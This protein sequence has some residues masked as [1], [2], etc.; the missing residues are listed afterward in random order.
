MHTRSMLDRAMVATEVAVV[1]T[2]QSR[3][4]TPWCGATP[5]SAGSPGY[6]PEELTGRNCRI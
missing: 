6:Q 3:T 5:P 1:I 2:N 4:T